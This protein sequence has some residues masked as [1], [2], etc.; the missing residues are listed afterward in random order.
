MA[1]I[2]ND[3]GPIR[4]LRE[5]RGFCDSA[6][7]LCDAPPNDSHVYLNKNSMK[8]EQNWKSAAGAC[9]CSG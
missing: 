4:A 6:F 8:T 9:V 1:R 5:I 7:G 2:G 3:S